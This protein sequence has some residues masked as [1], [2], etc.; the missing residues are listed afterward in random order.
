MTAF[1]CPWR[2]LIHPGAPAKM[3]V[4]EKGNELSEA[5]DDQLTASQG[6]EEEVLPGNKTAA[7]THQ[8]PPFK[9]F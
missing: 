4:A 6:D 2:V 8:N 7:F 3:T 9:F 5:P 1:T